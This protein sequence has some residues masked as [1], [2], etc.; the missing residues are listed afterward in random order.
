MGFGAEDAQ[1][2]L[3]QGAGEPIKGL[4]TF[5]ELEFLLPRQ[6]FLVYEHLTPAD[7]TNRFFASQMK[8]A[9]Y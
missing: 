7:I 1:I 8:S 9:I 2:Q 3:A 4:F 5:Q 6:G